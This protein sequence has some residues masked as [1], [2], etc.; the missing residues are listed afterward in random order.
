MITE[1]RHYSKWATTKDMSIGIGSDS[2]NP[3]ATRLHIP[4][5]TTLTW[6][7]DSASGNVWFYVIIDGKQE[8]G[9][10]ECGRITNLIKTGDIELIDN[11]DG[12][13]AYAGD[14]LQKLL[15]N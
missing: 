12:L 14:F 9:K 7:D 8:R 5:G 10:I 6:D 11:G 1:I 4:K 15:N 3:N 13:R 2:R